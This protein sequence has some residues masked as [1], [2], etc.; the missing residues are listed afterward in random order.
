VISI[1]E[2]ARRYKV[3]PQTIWRW[4]RVGGLKRFKRKFDRRT[5][6]AS[7]ALAALRQQSEFE[8]RK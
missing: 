5:Y 1:E 2:A 7:A 4:V 8:E 6:V 3:T